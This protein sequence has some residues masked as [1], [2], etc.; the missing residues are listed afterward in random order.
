[1]RLV[2]PKL[3][4]PLFCFVSQVEKYTYLNNGTGMYSYV[5]H[6]TDRKSLYHQTSF[7]K[8]SH[9]IY[10]WQENYCHNFDSWVNIPLSALTLY[11]K[12]EN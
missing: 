1:M 10:I 12:V 4:N 8:L 5:I 11:E 6:L 7:P 2:K 3:I 9:S